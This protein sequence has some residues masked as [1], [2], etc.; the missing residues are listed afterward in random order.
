MYTTD[1]LIVLNDVH[2]HIIIHYNVFIFYSV[3]LVI[4]PPVVDCDTVTISFSSNGRTQCQLDRRYFTE[5]QS[6][7]HQS[8][9]RGGKHTVTIRATDGR[10][11]Y[12]QDS[13]TFNIILGM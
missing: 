10:G 5:C 9:L 2:S 7:Y 13:V 8:G 6:P 11:Q 12:K 1:R 4:S 3:E